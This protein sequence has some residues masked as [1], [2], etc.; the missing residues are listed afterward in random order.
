MGPT[1]SLVRGTVRAQDPVERRAPLGDPPPGAQDAEAPGAPLGPRPLRGVLQ[2][3]DGRLPAAQQ[4]S[5]G[6]AEVPLLFS[7]L[8][9]VI[10]EKNVLIF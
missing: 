10:I 9:K 6:P 5:E 3:G 4:G 1:F 7:Q 2:A 8:P